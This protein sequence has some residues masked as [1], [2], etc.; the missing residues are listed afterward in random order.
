MKSNHRPVFEYEYQDDLI[1]W[2]WSVR[3]IEKMYW[4]TWK[5]KVENVKI[6]SKLTNT[7]LTNKIKQEIYEGVISNEH[8]KQEKLTGMYKVRGYGKKS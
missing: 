4:K 2:T 5:P 8:I 7:S 6:L 3:P 1:K